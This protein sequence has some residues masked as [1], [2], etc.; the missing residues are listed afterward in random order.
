MKWGRRSLTPNHFQPHPRPL[1]EEGGG[2]LAFEMEEVIFGVI[3]GAS[4]DDI[5]RRNDLTQMVV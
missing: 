2:E 5:K 1:P 4:M 3:G